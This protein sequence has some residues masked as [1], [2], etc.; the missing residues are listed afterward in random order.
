MLTCTA[1]QEFPGY[2]WETNVGYGTRD[3]RNAIAQLGLTRTTAAAS[4]RSACISPCRFP[5][6]CPGPD[7]EPTK[8]VDRLTT[9]RNAACASLRCGHA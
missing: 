2:G 4:R 7:G 1:R 6:R 8:T 9:D 5:E 3:H